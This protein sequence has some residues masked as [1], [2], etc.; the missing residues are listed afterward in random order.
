MKDHHPEWQV[1][2][3]GKVVNVRLTTHWAGNTVTRSDF[4]LAEEMNNAASAAGRFKQYERFPWEN[5]KT[6]ASW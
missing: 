2:D 1:S 6:L 4:E 5:P 3:G